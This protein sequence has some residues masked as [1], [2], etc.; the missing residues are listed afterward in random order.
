MILLGVITCMIFANKETPTQLTNETSLY[1]YQYQIASDDL[2]EW[3]D[4]LEKYECRDCPLGYK[5]IDDNGKFSYGCLQFQMPTFKRYSTK[6]YPEAV[7]NIEEADWENRI[8]DC[9]I[10]K[11]L[12]YKMIEDDWYNWNHWKYSILV[13]GLNKPPLP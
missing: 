10:Q 13:R 4:E 2:L 9:E 12:T 11:N 5:R 7:K 1:L 3:I 8:Y 6:Y